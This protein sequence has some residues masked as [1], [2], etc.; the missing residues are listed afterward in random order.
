MGE[1]D[2]VFSR[3]IVISCYELINESIFG[4]KYATFYAE[5]NETSFIEIEL[6][7]TEIW[8]KNSNFDLSNWEELIK[9]HYFV[10]GTHKRVNFWFKICQ[11]LC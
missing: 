1:I 9:C 2:L 10:L 3:N 4:S 7:L 8:R 11:I 6:Y 5:S